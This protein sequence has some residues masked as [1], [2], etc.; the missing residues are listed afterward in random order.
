MRRL[1]IVILLMWITSFVA[2]ARLAAQDGEKLYK[3]NCA[4]CH[5][6]GVERAPLLS[7]L[8]LYFPERILAAMESGP[9]ISMAN[10]ASTADRRAIAEYVSGRK[11]AQPLNLTPASDAMC[12]A[13]VKAADPLNSG[14]TGPV[15][16]AW[17][18]DTS[19]ARFQDEVM[20][21]LTADDVPKLKLKWVFGF[22]GDI[23]ATSQ[24]TLVN[25]RIFVGSPS[26]MIYALSAS[27]GCVHW[28]FKADGGVR[29][30]ITIGQI[31]T[32]ANARYAAFFGDLG[33]NAYAID[34]TSGRLLWKIKVDTFPV[35]RITGSPTYYNGRLYVPVSS[36]E[37]PAAG[38]SPTYECC[39][40]RGSVASIDA[41][42]GRVLWKTYTIPEPPQP[43]TKNSAGTQLWGPSGAAVWSSPA[44][45]PVRNAIYITTGNNYSEPGTKT[46]AAFI[47]LNIRDGK[48]LWSR[49]MTEGDT[50]NSSCRMPDKTNCP[51][52]E[53]PDFDF[54]AP[55]ILLTLPN[56]QRA[57]I[58]GQKSAKVHAIDPDREGAVI[59]QKQIGRGGTMGGVQWGSAADSSNVYVALSDVGRIMLP[60]SLSTNVDPKVGG[61]MFALRLSDGQQVWHTPPARCGDRPRCSPAQ[62]AAVS[63]LP[64]VA[65]SGSVDGHMRAYSTIDGQV[66]WDFDALRSF[67]T[68]NKVPARGGS[69]DGPGAVIGGGMIFFNAGYA[70][71]GGQPGNVLLGFS[72]DGK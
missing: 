29:T 51:Q 41:A 28:Y 58:A 55:P 9:M 17:G 5:D 10:R 65:F 68:V 6:G 13:D 22:P 31:G 19:N 7:T 45:D 14:L 48:I 18:K 38:A 54:S 32:G 61:G 27:T 52:K 35:A 30:A 42:T 49:Q 46:S 37:E 24:P 23:S 40:F 72:V 33:A 60:Y 57:L 56:G 4:S 66:I 47:A 44:I 11:M 36:G 67:D 2:P 12:P 21:G 70:S 26:G 53:G 8:R 64:G 63:A 3:S 39:K 1:L 43:T 69:F 71:G 16:S 15:W 62:S 25:G 34:A 59:W 20:A 50:W